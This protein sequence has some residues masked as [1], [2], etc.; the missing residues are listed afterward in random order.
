MLLFSKVVLLRD[1]S[2][3]EICF[4]L[5]R[6]WLFVIFFSCNIVLF[7][8]ISNCCLVLILLLVVDVY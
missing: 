1:L 7:N 8:E 4:V 6:S 5:L 2:F 3:K